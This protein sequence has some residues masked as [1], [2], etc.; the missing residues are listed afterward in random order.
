MNTYEE[1]EKVKRMLDAAYWAAVTA[2]NVLKTALEE[3]Q[4]AVDEVERKQE[5]L[6]RKMR[7]LE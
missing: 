3:A 4:T 6:S 1:M 5:D 7:E 2:R